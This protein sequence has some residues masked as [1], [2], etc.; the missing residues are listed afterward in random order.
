MVSKNLTGGG[1]KRIGVAV[2]REEDKSGDIP[3]SDFAPLKT[4]AASAVGDTEDR[5]KEMRRW[6][7]GEKSQI[8]IAECRLRNSNSANSKSIR[9][10]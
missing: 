8:E 2:G 4:G 9:Q 3:S 1:N 5:D 7:N 6:G 10:S